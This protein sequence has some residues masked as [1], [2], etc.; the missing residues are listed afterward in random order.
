M[1]QTQVSTKYQ[2]VIPK[3]IRKQVPVKPG[4]KMDVT[5]SGETIIL[6]P[7]KSTAHW[8]WPEDYL[9]NLPNPWKGQDSQKYIE[10]ERN[11][12]DD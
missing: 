9:K 3:A 4:Q 12:W 10:N 11:S 1:Q 7:T 5:V 8:K 2:V 6:S